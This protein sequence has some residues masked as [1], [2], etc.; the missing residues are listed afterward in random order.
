MT[1][2][3]HEIVRSCVKILAWNTSGFAKGNFTISAYATLVQNEVNVANNLF[4]DGAVKVVIP[5]DVNGDGFVDVLDAVL[6][7]GA[8]GANPTWPNWNPNAD[9][10]NDQIVDLF[11][12]VI[13]ASHAG[14]HYS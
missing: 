9:I 1:N 11:D 6:L 10:D 2:D 3:V 5:G 7:A 12:A 8:A 14:E 13:L 4:T